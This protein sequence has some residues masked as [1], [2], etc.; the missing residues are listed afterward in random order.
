MKGL[1]LN[2]GV[3][4][5]SGGL[6]TISFLLLFFILPPCFSQ[7]NPKYE[8]QAELEQKA[9]FITMDRL[10]NLYLCDGSIVYKFDLNGQLLF[11][12][13]AFSKGKISGLDVANPFKIMV[14]SKDFMQ[15]V[16]LDQKLAPIQTIHSLSEWNLYAPACVCA[17]YDNG[18]WVYDEVQNQLFR[19]DANRKMTNKSQL[20]SQIW[21]KKVSP[22]GIKETESGFLVV[23]DAENGLLIFD[24]FGTYLKTIPIFANRLFFK[25]DKILYVEENL[26]KTIE[27]STLQ[28]NNYLLPQSD[29]L[30][31]CIEN[32]KIIVLTK[33]HKVIIYR[34][35]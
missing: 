30:Q 15:I 4:C 19:Y 7:N 11:T 14:F 21:E 8:L 22:I 9:D 35:L 26:L 2:F 28:T 24:R 10:G 25:E 34:Y 13:S 3:A 16:F 29:I 27:I 23:N 33:E 17:S 18:I 20:L 6:L 1:L 31:A 32:K 5:K 12:Y